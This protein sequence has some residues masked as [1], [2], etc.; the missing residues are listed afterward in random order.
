MRA[1]IMDM[2]KRPGEII[3]SLERGEPV[4]ILYRGKVKGT[5]QPANE[6]EGHKMPVS[7]HPAFGMWKDRKDMEDVDQFVRKLRRG[8]NNAL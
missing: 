8:R 2:R 1:T 6:K 5:I 3:K 4:T 7:A